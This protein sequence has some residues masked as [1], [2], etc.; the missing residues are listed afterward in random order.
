MALLFSM[1][2]QVPYNTQSLNRYSYTTNNPLN[3]VDPSG[4]S[5][6]KKL[7]AIVISVVITVATYGAA[8]G[9]GGW[10]AGWGFGAGTLGNAVVSCAVAGALGGF[11]SGLTFPQRFGP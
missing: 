10:A 6:F 1:A 8:S 2:S 4:F 7:M 9:V 5:F 3:T 11:A